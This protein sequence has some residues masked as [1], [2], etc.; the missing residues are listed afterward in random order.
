[1][2]EHPLGPDGKAYHKGA[3]RWGKFKNNFD[4]TKGDKRAGSGNNSQAGMRK[5]KFAAKS[6]ATISDIDSKSDNSRA[7]VSMV[8]NGSGF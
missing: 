2:M 6:D 5:N 3:A 7:D 1:M 8:S 4:K